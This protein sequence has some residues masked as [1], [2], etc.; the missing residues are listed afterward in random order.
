MLNHHH[1]HPQP[2]A[3][4]PD[5]DPDIMSFGPPVQ[6]IG[7]RG[8]VVRVNE[9]NKAFRVT[10]SDSSVNFETNNH[11]VLELKILRTR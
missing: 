9:L 8:V 10:I 5:P 7:V 4:G 1:H 3:F 2:P 11:S 6:K